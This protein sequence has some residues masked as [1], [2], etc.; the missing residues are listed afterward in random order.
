MGPT[1]A[2]APGIRR[3][4]SGTPPIVGMLA[5]QDMLDLLDEVGVA[6]VREKSVGLTSYAVELADELLAPLGVELA[7]PRDPAL[8]GGHITL[9][10][11][12]MREVTAALW[13]RDVIPDYRD[14]GGLRL[15]LSPLSTSYDEVRRGLE[16]V[17]GVLSG[18]GA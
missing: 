3:W 4:L 6:A 16:Q 9:G 7:S 14:P 2:P 5:V 12:A 10:H 11:P 13:Q 15:G 1:Y 18:L 8:R 17:R